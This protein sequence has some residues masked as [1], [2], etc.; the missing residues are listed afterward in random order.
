MGK[1]SKNLNEKNILSFFFSFFHYLLQIL[2][3]LGLLTLDKH[4]FFCWQLFIDA[5]FLFL[6]KCYIY[7]KTLTEI[8]GIFENCI[9][10]SK[11]TLDFTGTVISILR[12]NEHT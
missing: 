2:Y 10:I 7:S 5:L 8:L 9:R 6:D 1:T 12:Q 3:H 11:W 4:P